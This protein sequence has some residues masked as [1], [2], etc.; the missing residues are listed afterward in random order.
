MLPWHYT[1]LQEPQQLMGE[2]LLMLHSLRQLSLP[3][4]SSVPCKNQVG[5]ALIGLQD[6]EGIINYVIQRGLRGRALK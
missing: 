4:E 2:V 3:E 5:L 6:L 1:G